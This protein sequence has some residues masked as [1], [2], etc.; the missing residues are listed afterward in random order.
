MFSNV[1]VILTLCHTLMLFR[2]YNYIP[3]CYTSHDVDTVI[4]SIVFNTQ[5]VKGCRL[6]H[7]Y[8]IMGDSTENVCNGEKEINFLD[9]GEAVWFEYCI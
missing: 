3:R 2:S 9:I 7:H 1:D 6:L 8:I 5:F 4:Q